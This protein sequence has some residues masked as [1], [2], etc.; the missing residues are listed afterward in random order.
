MVINIQDRFLRE[1]TETWFDNYLAVGVGTGTTPTSGTEVSLGAG[2]QIGTTSSNFNT[3]F[4]SATSSFI[5]TGSTT[6]VRLFTLST[7]E[8]NVLPVNVGE[9]GLFKT[10]AG[11]TDMASRAVLNV[12]QTKD[13]TVQW[14]IRFQGSVKRTT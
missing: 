12:A 6:F 14:N 8:P 5:G 10:A 11:T 1:I 2:V 4:E 3:L 9:L 7:T 13:N